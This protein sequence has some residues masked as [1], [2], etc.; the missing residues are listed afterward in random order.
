MVQKLK[1]EDTDHL[2]R[3]FKPP[4]RIG[5]DGKLVVV[6]INANITKNSCK[7]LVTEIEEYLQGWC[8]GII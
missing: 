8:N 4:Y 6:N 5:C 3:D 1:R 2:V 7:T